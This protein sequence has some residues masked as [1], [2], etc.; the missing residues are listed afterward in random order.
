MSIALRRTA[1]LSNTITVLISSR[2]GFAEPPSS[3]GKLRIV[4]ATS[5]QTGLERE[6]LPAVFSEFREGAPGLPGALNSGEFLIVD[7]MAFQL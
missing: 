3:A 5:R 1:P 6:D 2:T 4:T 7:V